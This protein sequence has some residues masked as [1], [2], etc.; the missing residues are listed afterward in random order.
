M[1]DLE[2]TFEEQIHDLKKPKPALIFPETREPRVLTAAEKLLE[3]ADI[4]LPDSR[5]ELASFMQA[6]RIETSGTS[7][8]FLD[9]INFF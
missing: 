4:F 5:N 8:D 6:N 1:I 7:A 2:Y 9:R 3:F